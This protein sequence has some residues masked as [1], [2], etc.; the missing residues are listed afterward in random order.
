M[1]KKGHDM[2]Y[3]IQKSTCWCS[4]PLDLELYLPYLDCQFDLH[5]KFFQVA[6]SHNDIPNLLS[7]LYFSSSQLLSPKN[8]KLRYSSL[9]LHVMTTCSQQLHYMPSTM[10]TEESIHWVKHLLRI[11]YFEYC[12]HWELYN[13]KIDCPIPSQSLISHLFT[14]VG[15]LNSTN[16]HIHKVTN[17]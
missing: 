8:M 17:E 6:V 4:C 2:P 1:T 11:A 3:W 9:S 16:S 7:S 12:K 15:A 10:S 14:K 5:N 13:P